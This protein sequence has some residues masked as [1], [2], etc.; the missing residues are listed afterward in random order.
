[1]MLLDRAA[2]EKGNIF[3]TLNAKAHTQHKSNS[4][5]KRQRPKLWFKENIWVSI[6]LFPHTLNMWFSKHTVIYLLYIW[7]LC[8]C[9]SLMVCGK[10][11]QKTF[12]LNC[13]KYYNTHIIHLCFIWRIIIE[14]EKS[15]ATIAEQFNKTPRKFIAR[16]IFKNFSSTLFMKNA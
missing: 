11:H 14:E 6:D 10:I 12:S 3:S 16:R 2:S 13:H 5:K 9:V 1:M 8:R 7:R 15:I 4:S